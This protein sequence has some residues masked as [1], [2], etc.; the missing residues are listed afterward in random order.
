MRPKSMETLKIQNP[1]KTFFWI[2][3]SV[4]LPLNGTKDVSLL[5]DL[6][7]WAEET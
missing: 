6:V 5:L 7:S 4:A 1:S 2:I 3:M